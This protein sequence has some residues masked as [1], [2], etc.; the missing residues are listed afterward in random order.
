MY[1]ALFYAI[2]VIDIKTKI[3]RF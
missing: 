1:L 2:N 3:R